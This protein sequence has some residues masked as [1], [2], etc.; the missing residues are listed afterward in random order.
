MEQWKIFETYIVERL[1]ELDNYCSRTPG[2]GNKGI[3]GD[4]R[5]TKIPLHFECKQ[6]NTQ[7]ITIK[8]D[9]WEKLNNEIPLHVDK[10]PV[11]CLENKD[12]KRF[13]VL[14][15]DDFLDIFVEYYKLKYG[16]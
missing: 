12:K 5:T 16:E 2:S 13:A 14:N 8:M 3:K 9:V 7:D 11:Y 15:L 6:R 1:K 4:I 10:I